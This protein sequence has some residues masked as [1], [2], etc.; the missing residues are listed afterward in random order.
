M[1][2]QRRGF[3][4]EVFDGLAR[5]TARPLERP[6]ETFNPAFRFFAMMRSNLRMPR[7]AA[8]VGTN[9]V[10]ARSLGKW[11]AVQGFTR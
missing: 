1:T 2:L 5:A 9:W 3:L 8:P 6:F 10:P 4:D 11:K 7:P